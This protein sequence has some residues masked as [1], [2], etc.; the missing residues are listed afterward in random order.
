MPRAL[1]LA[2]AAGRDETGDLV[3]AQARARCKAGRRS[4]IGQCTEQCSGRRFE[5]ARGGCLTGQQRFDLAPERQVART[6]PVQKG[7]SVC[8][9][10]LDRLQEQ[11]L[12][13]SPPLGIT[14][15]RIC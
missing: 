5:E 12:D 15:R 10:A 7:A 11:S 4:E 9:G 6:Y 14:R 2:H 3:R 8:I 1:H 13:P